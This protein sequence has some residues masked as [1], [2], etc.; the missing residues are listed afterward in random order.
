MERTWALIA[1][2]VTFTIT[3]PEYTGGVRSMNDGLAF[4]YRGQTGNVTTADVTKV[5]EGKCQSFLL[6]TGMH[7]KYTRRY[8]RFYCDIPFILYGSK[9]AIC[10][11]GAW[12]GSQPLCIA[13]RCPNI[14]KSEPYPSINRRYQGALLVFS[15]PPGMSLMGQSQLTCDG[16]KW[17]GQVPTCIIGEADRSCGFE[18]RDLCGWTNDV[19]SSLSWIRTNGTTPTNLTGPSTGHSPDGTSGYYVYM[20][21]SGPFGR[22]EVARLLSPWYRD[23]PEGTCFRFFYHMLGDDSHED[24]SSLF[25][26][27]RDQRSVENLMFNTTGSHGDQWVRGLVVLREDYELMQIVIQATRTTNWAHDVA[28]DDVSLYNCSKGDIE[29][30]TE[31]TSVTDHVTISTTADVGRQETAKSPI[32]QVTKQPI[33]NATFGKTLTESSMNAVTDHP[34]TEKNT[35][36]LHQQTKSEIR[37]SSNPENFTNH[38]AKNVSISDEVLTGRKEV[39]QSSWTPRAP[40]SKNELYTLYT[41]M[42]VTVVIILLLLLTI[43]VGVQVQW[44]RKRAPRD[45]TKAEVIEMQMMD[46]YK[47]NDESNDTLSHNRNSS[48]ENLINHNLTPNVIFCTHL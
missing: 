29:F 6:T 44:R 16:E 32:R 34:S 2:A 1:V 48:S 27:V 10:V 7:I 11:G 3:A 15:C 24:F 19:N 42:V 30:P 38:Y 9:R 17:S 35:T 37:N 25:V 5:T 31:V 45:Q 41:G 12:T 47:I 14:S 23:V 22:N 8:A 43:L 46:G 33:Y 36:P 18:N 20:E 4:Y 39:V 28:I 13:N 26:Y 21:S 40:M